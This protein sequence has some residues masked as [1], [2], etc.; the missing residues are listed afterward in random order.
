[1]N[2][3]ENIRI[4]SIR[5]ENIINKE[6]RDKVILKSDLKGFIGNELKVATNQ[7]G[8]FFVSCT[9]E[10]GNSN[11]LSGGMYT[12]VYGSS[13]IEESVIITVECE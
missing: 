10:A 9:E 12:F 3:Q 6:Y 2:G 11:M 8:W 13:V 4:K 5:S 1:M 7:E